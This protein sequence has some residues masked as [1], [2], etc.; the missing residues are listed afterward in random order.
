MTHP[1]NHQKEKPNLFSRLVSWSYPSGWRFMLSKVNNQIYQTFSINESRHGSCRLGST[2]TTRSCMPGMRTKGMPLSSGCY[3]RV[4]I[5]TKMSEL[6]CWEPI[7]LSMTI[8][9]AHHGNFEKFAVEENLRKRQLR[10]F[11]SWSVRS[12]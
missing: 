7:L 1:P 11:F 3:R 5:L 12:F 6:C 4:A 10:I 8:T 9:F 2:R